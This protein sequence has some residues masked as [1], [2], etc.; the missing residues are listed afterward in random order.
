MENSV[1][2]IRSTIVKYYENKGYSHEHAE[3]HVPHDA[4]HILWL[5]KKIQEEKGNE[6]TGSQ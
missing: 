2:E 1:V 4:N 6:P 5:Y 3:N